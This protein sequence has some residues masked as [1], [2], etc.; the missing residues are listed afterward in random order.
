MGA[1]GRQILEELG[2]K[3]PELIKMLNRAFADE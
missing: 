2:T 1:R 3:I